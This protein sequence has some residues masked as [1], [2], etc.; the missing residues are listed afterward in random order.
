[1]QLFENYTIKHRDFLLL[2]IEI[3]T[4]KGKNKKYCIKIMFVS[5]SSSLLKSFRFLYIP[6]KLFEFKNEQT[7]KSSAVSLTS[8]RISK[9]YID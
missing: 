7:F 8:I 9:S 4:D 6:F 5:L 2:K 3:Q 1:M